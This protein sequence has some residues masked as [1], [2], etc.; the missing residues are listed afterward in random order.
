MNSL[1]HSNIQQN[2]SVMNVIKNVSSYNSNSNHQNS[3]TFYTG[4]LGAKRNVNDN[5]ANRGADQNVNTVKSGLISFNN[6]TISLQQP[7]K[8]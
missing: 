4:I 6:P 1:S 2:S 3:A 8:E 5:I 7:Q